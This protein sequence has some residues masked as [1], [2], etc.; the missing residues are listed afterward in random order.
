MFSPI[1]SAVKSLPERSIGSGNGLY[2]SKKTNSIVDSRHAGM[3][4]PDTSHMV[5]FRPSATS[6]IVEFR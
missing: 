2:A 3:V 5:P 4:K 6:G 1:K